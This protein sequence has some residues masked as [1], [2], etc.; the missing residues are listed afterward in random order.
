MKAEKVGMYFAQMAVKVR[1]TVASP[2]TGW[3]FIGFT[4]GKDQCQNCSVWDKVVAVGAMWGN[5]PECA[6]NLQGTCPNN[7]PMSETWYNTGAPS[8]TRDSLGWGKR[9]AAPMDVAKR[10]NVITLDGTRYTGKEDDQFAASSCMSCHGS[11]Q[12]PF[13]ANLYPSPNMVFPEDGEEFLFFT[14]GSKQ[15]ANWFQNRPPGEPMSGKGHAGAFVSL[16]Y[17]MMVTL[18]LMTA[19]SGAGEDAF[20]DSH[21]F[22]H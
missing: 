21:Q 1:D 22:G 13:A 2:V 18:A 15:W 7:G 12:Y 17:D 5:N 8:W 3:V 6:D 20:L 14:P 10:H 19:L 4:Y 9:L 11:A 16:D